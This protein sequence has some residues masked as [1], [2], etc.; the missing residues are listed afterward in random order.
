M[1]DKARTIV[2]GVVSLIIGAAGGLWYGMM[3]VD[4]A[5]QKLMVAMQEK[6]Q[7][8]QNANRLRR[9]NDDAAKKYGKD[10]GKLVMAVGAAESSAPPAAA[11][12]QAQPALAPAAAAPAP[13]PAKLIDNGRAILAARDGFRASLDGV[14]ASMNSEF[15]ALAAELGNAAP[16]SE[17]VK[18]ILESLKQ[19][20]PQ[21]ETNM[22]A[23][24]RKLLVDL[25]VLQAAP[26]PKPAAAPAPTAAPAPAPTAAPAPVPA[27]KK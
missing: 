24:T 10:L 2:S 23:A 11:P 13:D 26:A 3:Q 19:N 16:D 20:W 12:A 4:E 1:S 22:E 18:Q 8:V 7:A 27:E 9:M 17:K 25:G 21:K 5:T 6:D 14:R 15:D